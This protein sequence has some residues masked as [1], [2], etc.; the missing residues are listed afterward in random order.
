MRARVQ[1]ERGGDEFGG[2]ARER[3][4]VD[5]FALHDPRIAETGRARRSAQTV[6]NRDRPA[7]RLQ[8]ERRAQTHETGAQHQRIDFFR[9]INLR[10][11]ALYAAPASAAIEFCGSGA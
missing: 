1:I 6:Q 9:Q 11:P 4:G 3:V 8:R 7:A 10:T 2:A 5:G